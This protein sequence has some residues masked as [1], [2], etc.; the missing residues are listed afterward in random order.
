M[1]RLFA[2]CLLQA[3]SNRSKIRQTIDSN[4]ARLNLV[5]DNDSLFTSPNLTRFFIIPVKNKL[6]LK[7]DRKVRLIKVNMVLLYPGHF[8]KNLK[9]SRNFIKNEIL[10]NC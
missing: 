7:S 3:L 5:I 9:L 4:L 6:E 8:P 2:K 10:F 1:L